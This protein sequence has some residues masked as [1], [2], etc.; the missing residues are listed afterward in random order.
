MAEPPGPQARV[1]RSRSNLDAFGPHVVDQLVEVL[2][3][4]ERSL[5]VERTALRGPGEQLVEVPTVAQTI[6]IPVQG[7]V[8]SM[9]SP[10]MATITTGTT[11]LCMTSF[12]VFNVILE[13]ARGQVQPLL[14]QVP[15]EDEA[16]TRLSGSES[17]V[18]VAGHT[19]QI[20]W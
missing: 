2:K 19:K 3:I 5:L 11:A 14:R 13:R 18:W 16:R 7:C 9:T 17:S 4:I 15:A 20:M 12:S 10:G 8:G 6:D 1:Q